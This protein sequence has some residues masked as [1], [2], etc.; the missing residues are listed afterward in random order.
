MSRRN[1]LWDGASSVNV[2][3]RKRRDDKHVRYFRV[4][5]SEQKLAFRITSIAVVLAIGSGAF[6]LFHWEASELR[7]ASGGITFLTLFFIVLSSRLV[8]FIIKD[9]IRHPHDKTGISIADDEALD[10]LNNFRMGHAAGDSARLAY[11]PKVPR[12]RPRSRR[13]SRRSQ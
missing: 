8:R 11:R 2:R 4:S 12:R 6:E 13:G 7:L 10:G 5:R 3:R 9:S 1:R